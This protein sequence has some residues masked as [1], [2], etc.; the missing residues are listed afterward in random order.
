[1]LGRSILQTLTSDPQWCTIHALSHRSPSDSKSSKVHHAK[2]DLL[3]APE[4]LAMQL[5]GAEVKIQA[6]YLFFCAYLQR[7]DE[8]DM[9]KVNATATARQDQ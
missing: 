7:G 8:A 9:E 5:K 4:T 1:I 2:I 6:E 3:A